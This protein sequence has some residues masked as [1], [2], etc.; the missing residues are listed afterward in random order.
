MATPHLTRNNDNPSTLNGI[1]YNGDNH[2]LIIRHAG[3]YNNVEM[4]ATPVEEKF[5]AEAAWGNATSYNS[6]NSNLMASDANVI[7]G[8]LTGKINAMTTSNWTNGHKNIFAYYA[9]SGCPGRCRWQPS[10]VTSQIQQQYLEFAATRHILKFDLKFLPFGNFSQVNV[11]L[12][13][14]NPSFLQ[15]VPYG[16]GALGFDFSHNDTADILYSFK[17]ALEAPSKLEDGHYAFCRFISNGFA[18][19]GNMSSGGTPCGFGHYDCWDLANV[20][21]LPSGTY[22]RTMTPYYYD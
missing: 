4:V 5:I 12:R 7:V 8:D 20:S 22:S 6:I 10:S 13:F 17:D 15:Q 19:K 14:T 3:T 2:L 1:T 18:N 21:G 11:Y 9:R 16:G